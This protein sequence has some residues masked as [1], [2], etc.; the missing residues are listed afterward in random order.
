MWLAPRESQIENVCPEKSH[1]L[2]KPYLGFSSSEFIEKDTG[3]GERTITK[4]VNVTL[5]KR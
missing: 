4:Y 2:C 3:R 1:V 5:V